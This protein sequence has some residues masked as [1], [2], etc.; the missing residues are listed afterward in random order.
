MQ[1]VFDGHNDVLLRLWENSRNGDDPIR[2][3]IDGTQ[4]GHIDAPRS[5][6]GGLAGGICAIYVP[7]GHHIELGKPDANGHYD[8][9]LSPPLQRSPSLDIA[10]EIAAIALRLEEAG[11]W[12]LCRNGRELDA[13]LN[14]CRRPSYGRLRGNRR[15]S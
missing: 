10:V 13:A 12:K 3:F 8:T 2:E 11:A 7:S 1:R 6:K 15:R 14:L 5:R 4:T 9:P